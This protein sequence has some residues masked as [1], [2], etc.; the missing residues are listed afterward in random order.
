MRACHSVRVGPAGVVA[1][2]LP[3][4]DG[5]LQLQADPEQAELSFLLKGIP[6]TKLH[7]HS[8]DDQGTST[9]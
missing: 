1:A 4:A 9:L 7:A 6:Q 8:T 3:R 2:R 5:S